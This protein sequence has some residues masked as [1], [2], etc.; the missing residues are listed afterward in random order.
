MT[1]ESAYRETTEALRREV[2]TLR[3]EITRLKAKVPM[4]WRVDWGRCGD[5][6]VEV[7]LFLVGAAAAALATVYI[8]LGWSS[9]FVQRG[10]IVQAIATVLWC[11]AF[12]RRVPR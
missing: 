1:T 6:Y 11:V 9:P 3:A 7:L 2:E 5:V 12:V 4:R 10:S 8:A